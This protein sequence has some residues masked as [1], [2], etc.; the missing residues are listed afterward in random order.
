MKI[1]IIYCNTKTKYHLKYHIPLVRHELSK[2]IYD[3]NLKLELKNHYFEILISLIIAC[4]RNFIL[5]SIK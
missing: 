4:T 3:I 1:I 5:L 2:I